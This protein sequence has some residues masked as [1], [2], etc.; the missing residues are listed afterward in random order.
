MYGTLSGSFISFHLAPM[1]FPIS[2][3]AASGFS[4]FTESRTSLEKCINAD[5]G[6]LGAFLSFFCRFFGAFPSAASG[7]LREAL[8]SAF[9]FFCAGG[10]F[11]F[12]SLCLGLAFASGALLFGASPSPPSSPDRSALATSSSASSESSSEGSPSSSSPL[13]ILKSSS[14]SLT[15]SISSATLA[16]PP[17]PC[18]AS[19]RFSMR[20]F[21]AWAHSNRLAHSFFSMLRNWYCCSFL[22]VIM[23][24]KVFAAAIDSRPC[25]WNSTLSISS[26]VISS[27]GLFTKKKAR[28]SG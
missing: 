26:W 23:R 6:P 2:P 4:R 24:S 7:A 18:C 14:S 11:G 25:R 9:C 8:G 16:V 13:P 10:G 27:G 1:I 19:A 12:S 21:L 22:R 3:N 5:I 28:S 17:G 20:R 15:S